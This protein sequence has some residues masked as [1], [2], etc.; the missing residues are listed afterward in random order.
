MKVFFE[1][2]LQTL[3][4]FFSILFIT[5]ILGRQQIS[6][7]TVHEYINGITFGSIAAT[8]ATDVNQRTWQHLIGL[9][10]FGGLTF[11]FSYIVTKNRTIAKVVQGEPVVV[12][13]DG[14]ILEK[15]LETFHYTVDDLFAMLRKKD[16]FD[17]NSV[18]YGILE[19]S[20]ELSVI[21]VATKENA[22]V[23]DLN[24]IPKQEDLPTEVIVMGNIIY[25]NL[26]KRNLPMKWLV[27]QLKMKAVTDIRDVYYA[28]VDANNQLYV[29]KVEDHLRHERK[30]R[31]DKEE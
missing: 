23:D 7:L 4:A 1:I 29:D 24:I 19:N 8:L 22:K 11:L 10:L 12:I 2:V 27:D 14:K 5:R 16:V 30:I 18:R 20:G 17:I 13:Q 15:N 28:S 9:F 31:E 3:L 25:E 6:Q 26:R 21:K